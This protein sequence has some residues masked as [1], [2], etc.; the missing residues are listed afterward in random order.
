MK[1]QIIDTIEKYD[2]III[3]RHVRPDPDAYGSQ[4]GLKELIKTNYP[5]KQVFASGTHDEL[6]NYLAKQ[7]E[8]TKEDYSGALVIVTDTGNTERIDADFY[9]EG[10]YIIKIDHHPNVDPYGDLKWV[11]TDS[12]S[13][14]EMIYELFLEGQQ[15][16]GWKMSDTAARLLFAGIVGDTGRFIFPSATVRTFEIAGE[17]IKYDFDRTKLFADMYEEDRRILHLKGYIYQN[18]IMDQKGMAYIK[19]NQTILKEFNVTASETS[20]LVGVLGD[21]RGIC[22]WVIFVE[23]KDQIRVRLRSKGPVINGLAAQYNGGGHPLASGA[24]VYNWHEAD[25]I[26]E[27]L[28]VLCSTN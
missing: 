1:R 5:N 3:H 11:D 21:V 20:Q 8:L 9:K 24:S 6:L 26:I 16:S 14:S 18:F 19:I 10:S 27:K 7:D 22:A 23:E 25:E 12:S 13:T 17:L 15:H 4:V 28:K 2:K